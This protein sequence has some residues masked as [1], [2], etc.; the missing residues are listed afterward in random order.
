MGRL[1]KMAL[2]FYSVGSH[3]HHHGYTH[4]IKNFDLGKPIGFNSLGRGGK[5]RAALSVRVTLPYIP[6]RLTVV[7]LHATLHHVAC[8]N[9]K[10]YLK[11]DA[12]WY[13]TEHHRGTLSDA[14][15]FLR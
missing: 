2:W 1:G 13:A 5:E 12:Q 3:S 14:V 15:D 10:W 7:G 4:S 9:S 8:I 11:M 6:C